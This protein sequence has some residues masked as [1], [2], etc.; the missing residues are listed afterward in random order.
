MRNTFSEH[1]ITIFIFNKVICWLRRTCTNTL[2]S[3]YYQ[4]WIIIIGCIFTCLLILCAY[5][6]LICVFII[7][8]CYATLACVSL[9]LYNYSS[10]IWIIITYIFDFYS[11][12]LHTILFIL[13]TKFI[14]STIWNTLILVLVSNQL[15]CITFTFKTAFNTLIFVFFNYIVGLVLTKIL[16]ICITWKFLYIWPLINITWLYT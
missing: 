5:F 10:I 3:I 4:E 11:T 7:C 2:W 9:F 12:C 1:V 13:V 15:I 8:T 16:P 14:V 6:L